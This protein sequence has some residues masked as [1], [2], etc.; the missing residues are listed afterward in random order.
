MLLRRDL[1]R[2]ARAFFTALALTVSAAC[3][4]SMGHDPLRPD[5]AASDGAIDLPPLTEAE[6]VIVRALSPTELDLTMTPANER[7]PYW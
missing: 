6:W 4:E 3:S 5:A 7:T 1:E 2:V